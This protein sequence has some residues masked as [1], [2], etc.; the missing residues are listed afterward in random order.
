MYEGSHTTTVYTC[1]KKKKQNYPSFKAP[2]PPK[3][4]KTCSQDSHLTQS[5]SD[6]QSE[7]SSLAK[8]SGSELTPS[9]TKGARVRG[10]TDQEAH[11][12]VQAGVHGEAS[13]TVTAASGAGAA[14][15]RPRRS[16]R[17]RPVP[18]R[19]T[20]PL[21]PGSEDQAQVSSRP[22]GPKDSVLAFHLPA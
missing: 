17:G 8:A 11:G 16:P 1:I 10:A 18:S 7:V 22:S 3:P 9:T 12:G 15:C 5:D 14:L 19:R 20:A 4:N 13:D 2:L 6:L 21:L